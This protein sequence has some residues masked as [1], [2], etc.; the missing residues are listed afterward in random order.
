MNDILELEDGFYFETED[1]DL[2]GPFYSFKLA[3]TAL[4]AYDKW[5]HHDNQEKKYIKMRGH[6]ED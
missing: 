2:S 3:Q 1:G 6:Y 5:T 4:K